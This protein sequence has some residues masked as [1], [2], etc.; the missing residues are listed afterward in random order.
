[1]DELVALFIGLERRWRGEEM[2][3][4]WWRITSMVSELKWGNRRWG[5]IVLMGDL[6]EMTW[7]FSSASRTRWRVAHGGAW[8]GGTAGEAAVAQ[9]E[10]RKGMTPGWAGWAKVGL[11]TWAGSVGSRG[12][13]RQATREWD[14]NEE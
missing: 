6:K 13:R 14:E 7:C 4:R 8:G 11:V 1:M 9:S 5:D 3:G 12:K 10:P 2:A